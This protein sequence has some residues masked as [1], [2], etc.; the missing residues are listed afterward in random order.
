MKKSVEAIRFGSYLMQNK[1]FGFCR[2]FLYRGKRYRAK[3]LG[4]KQVLDSEKGNLW[5]AEMILSG[6][7]FAAVRYGGVE[8]H[9]YTEGKEYILGLRK[10]MRQEIVDT[11]SRQAGFFPRDVSYLPKYVEVI[12][13]TS[14]EIDF[15]ATYSTRMENYMIKSFMSHDAV[16]SDNRALEPYYF[17]HK[18]PWSTALAGKRVLV[19][20]PFADTIREQY[21]KREKL[22][23]DPDILPEFEL[24][25]LKAV[26]TIVGT[27]DERFETWFEALKWMYDEA[28]KIP[29]DIAI[30]GC[31]AYGQPLACMLKRAGKQAIHI[32]GATQIMFGI[33]G[34]R[35]EL[36]SPFI[37]SLFNENWVRPSAAETPLNKENN[38]FGGAYW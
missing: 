11:A 2:R 16:V 22:F 31:G 3:V 28:L 6:K 19:I 4:G 34:R 12:E 38:E 25:T 14:K 32:G 13:D 17:M 7:P 1:V 10:Q 29:F 18:N 21:K 36:N 27:K 37:S 26:Q 24:Q 8:M 5:L 9:T 23:E 15:L 35:W 33:R 20:H 30:L